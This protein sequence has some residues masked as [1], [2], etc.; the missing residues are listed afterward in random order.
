MPPEAR[1]TWSRKLEAAPLRLSALADASTDRFMRARDAGADLL[2]GRLRAQHESG[3]DDQEWQ[4]FVSYVPTL[5]FAPTYARRVDTWHDF[6][7]GAAK[8]WEWD[9]GWHRVPHGTDTAA[10]AAWTFAVNGTWQRWERDGGLLHHRLR[11]DRRRLYPPGGAA[12]PGG[13]G[14]RAT[15][16]RGRRPRRPR[17]LGR[18]ELHRAGWRAWAA[19]GWLPGW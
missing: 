19:A 8:S 4:P 17:R 1:L 10:Q 12:W 16:S 3:A 7:L 14:W 15:G 18:C 5:T 13:R 6:A 11:H 9:G 2:Y